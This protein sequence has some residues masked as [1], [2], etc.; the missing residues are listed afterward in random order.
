MG[1]GRPRLSAAAPRSAL[2][3][4]GD[5][6]GAGCLP[7]RGA[8]WTGTS[9]AGEESARF[10]GDGQRHAADRAGAAAT[11]RTGQSGS[12]R[13]RARRG[14][15]SSR[16]AGRGRGPARRAER[17]GGSHGPGDWGWR[18]APGLVRRAG[19]ERGREQTPLSPRREKARSPG[20]RGPAPGWPWGCGEPRG[21]GCRGDLWDREVPT[22][23]PST[24]PPPGDVGR[25][26]VGKT[27]LRCLK[28]TRWTV[29][30][31][32]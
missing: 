16:Q 21:Q 7:G 6:E 2:C 28:D 1:V 31:K 32:V 19:G 5:A 27:G 25:T 12:G 17:V 30:I 14:G 10:R 20:T 4:R 29:T 18:G 8:W 23:P 26:L 13:G 9:E 11:R 22:E 15:E 3:C 24:A